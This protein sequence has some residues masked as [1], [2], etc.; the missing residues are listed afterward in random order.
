MS[1]DQVLE[2]S[3]LAPTRQRA[4]I[5]TEANPEGLR[6]DGTAYELTVPEELSLVQLHEI[7]RSADDI[8]K[9]WGNA[10]ITKADQERLEKAMNGYMLLLI[11]GATAEV[12]ADLP[13]LTKQSVL[14]G[15]LRKFN[16][17]ITAAIGAIETETP[18]NGKG[19]GS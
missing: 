2:L 9:L 5:R 4:L 8:Q 16:V 19:S 12:V 6:P 15:F 13:G 17:A 3:T 10:A 18:A 7:S 14:L 11:H 1:T